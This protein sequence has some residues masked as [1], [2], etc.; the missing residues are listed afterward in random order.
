MD[1]KKLNRKPKV[2]GACQMF[3]IAK[4]KS[5]TLGKKTIF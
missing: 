2:D 5:R 3:A 1:F 4:E